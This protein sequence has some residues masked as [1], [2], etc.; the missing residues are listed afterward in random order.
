LTGL[1]FPGNKSTCAVWVQHPVPTNVALTGAAAGSGVVFVDWTNASD[2]ASAS[3]T[4]AASLIW[5]PP[6]SAVGDT[7]TCTLGAACATVVGT[8]A[9]ELNSSSL[10]QFA[11]PASKVGWWGLRAIVSTA[12][13][14]TTSCPVVLGYRVR[15]RAD[16]I[17]S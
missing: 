16:R 5:I 12:D 6:A 9:S 2:V 3:M 17:G 13:A 7:G 4:V 14:A 15:Y 1:A 8:A 11:T 10:F